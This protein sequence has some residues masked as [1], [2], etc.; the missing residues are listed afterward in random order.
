MLQPVGSQIALCFEFWEKHLL[1]NK[2]LHRKATYQQNILMLNNS[3]LKCVLKPCMHGQPAD[4]RGSPRFMSHSSMVNGQAR[5]SRNRGL[6]WHLPAHALKA[7]SW[8]QTSHFGVLFMTWT[9]NHVMASNSPQDKSG[10][11]PPKSTSLPHWIRARSLLSFCLHLDRAH[12]I[13]KTLNAGVDIGNQLLDGFSLLQ[14]KDCEV[15]RQ[16]KNV[17]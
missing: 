5:L 8:K 17:N 15:C 2:H 10:T 9:C 3:Q 7:T 14:K 16:D 13:V 11:S 4:Q 6:A 1:P 12:R